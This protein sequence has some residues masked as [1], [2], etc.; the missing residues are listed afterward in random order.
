MTTRPP[1][2]ASEPDVPWTCPRCG[3]V[4]PY[5]ARGVACFTPYGATDVV[6]G[7]EV[8]VVRDV[9]QPHIR[10]NLIEAYGL[11]QGRLAAMTLESFIPLTQ[12]ERSAKNA[13]LKVAARWAEGS[14]RSL[15]LW[16]AICEPPELRKFGRQELLYSGC[17]NGK[18]HLAVT[19]AKRA[20]DLGHSLR[21]V[22]EDELLA[23]IRD[24]YGDE[25]ERS[26]G[27]IIAELG[28]PW[29]LVLDD[30]G[31]AAVKNLTWYQ[32]ILYGVIDR[33][34]KAERPIVLTTNLPPD[35]LTARLGP[36]TMS[37]LSEMGV[38]VHLDGPDRRRM[39]GG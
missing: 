29:L 5:R 36:R 21:L 7:C 6:E 4:W 15:W 12:K 28:Q 1:S 13:S 30:V 27:Q 16:A 8:C 38:G 9:V 22:A 34:Y 33:R 39:K 14:G 24:S 35:E 31:T 20:L 11:D 32:S 37:R 17:G 23:G 2:P 10:A 25:A 3:E 26:E 18:T 19:L